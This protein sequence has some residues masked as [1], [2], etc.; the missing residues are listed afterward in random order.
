[1]FLL[2]FRGFQQKLQAKRLNE[3][4]DQDTSL[5]DVGRPRRTPVLGH[6]SSQRNCRERRKRTRSRE[7]FR[8]SPSWPAP[9]TGPAARSCLACQAYENLAEIKKSGRSRPLLG[10][11]QD[12]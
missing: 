1:M 11:E 6:R 12:I 10:S 5:E 7:Q 8:S 3:F 4:L 2:V 9:Q